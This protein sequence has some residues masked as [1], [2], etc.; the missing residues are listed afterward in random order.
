MELNADFN[1][2]AVVHAAQLDWIPSPMPGVERRMLDRVGDEVAR[3][4]SIVRY[5]PNSSF[6][7][8]VHTGGEEF[9]VLE[10]VFQDEQGDFLA[11]SYIRNPPE[12]KHQPGSELGCTIFVKLWQFDLQDR[13]HVH[14]DAYNRPQQNS[15]ERSGILQTPLF[16]DDRESVRLERWQPGA[17]ID[18]QPSGGLELLVLEGEFIEQEETFTQYS[19]LRLPI[20]AT[21]SAQAGPAG[22]YYW[23][24]EGHLRY[25][26]LDQLPGSVPKSK[27][28]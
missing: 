23:V 14:I 6:S 3:A 20:G 16:Q 21:L 12:S 1:Q 24:K 4:T 15:S 13:T 8:H 19:W 17:M 10:G 25:V 9:L 18:Y 5:A 2:R 11:G 26:D 7:P 27:T 28:H 22:C